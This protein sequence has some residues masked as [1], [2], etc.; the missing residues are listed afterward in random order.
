MCYLLYT[1]LL[2]FYTEMST[3]LI[4]AVSANIC[5]VSGNMHCYS[6]LYQSLQFL[7]HG[8]HGPTGETVPLP[9]VEADNRDRGY[10]SEVTL[11]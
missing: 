3:K 10:A 5:M 2:Q 7:L 6:T 11:A 1:L 4:H 9:V 8:V